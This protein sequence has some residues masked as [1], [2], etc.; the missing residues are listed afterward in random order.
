MQARGGGQAWALAGVQFFFTI[1]WTVYV[2]YLPGLLQSAGIAAAWSPR[3]LIADQLIFAV[4]DIVLGAF[5][6]RVGAAYRRLARLL[7]V[8]SSLSALAFLLLPFWGAGSPDILLA[9]L[10]VWVISAAVVRGPTLVLLAKRAKAAQQGALVVA[11][12]AG[13]ALASAFAPFIGLWLKGSDPRLPFAL[14]GIVLL[15]AVLILLRTIDTPAVPDV[16][17]TP[18]PLSFARYLPRLLLLALAAFGFQLH[19]FINSAPLYVAQASRESLPWLMP[20]VWVGFFM[21]LPMLGPLAR[22]AGLWPVVAGGLLLLALASL[23]TG[24]VEG[25][26]LLVLLQLLVGVAW[27]AAF[28][29]LMELAAQAGMRGREGLFMGCFLAV[30]AVATLARIGV[31]SGLA[32]G[33]VS[34]WSVA[35]MLM[36]GVLAVIHA[37]RERASP[38][39]AEPRNGG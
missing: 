22:R 5:A 30:T 27:A 24:A 33:G 12:L 6:D 1:G 26:F 13:I 2:V 16:A 25:L 4:M 3:L 37:L 34:G 36:A 39:V 9:L 8:L 7:L 14:S 32:P 31:S 23:A 21:A 35:F 28:A 18:T 17:E 20:V 29:G 11:Y 38:S 15:A 10:A 19:V